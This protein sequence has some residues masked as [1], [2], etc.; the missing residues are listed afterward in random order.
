MNIN[1][2]LDAK[3]LGFHCFMLQLRDEHHLPLPGIELGEV[4]PK[5]TVDLR[6][7]PD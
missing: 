4:G 7:Y 2:I 5:V 3:E 1:L 6:M